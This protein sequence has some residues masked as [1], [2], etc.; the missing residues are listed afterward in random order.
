MNF[1]LTNE[2]ESLKNII[3]EFAETKIE[4][5]SFQ[6]DEKSI[7]PEKI[8]KEMGEL[9]IMGIPYPKKYGGAGMDIL[10]YAIAVE[11]LSRVDAGVGVALSA[12][13][14]LGSWPIME[15][16]TEE[17]KEK[18]LTPLAS[19]EKIGAFGLTEEN[20]GSDASNTET[21]AVLKGDHYI[22]NGAKIFITNGGYAQI[23]VIFAVT[24]PGIG[25][26][27][28]SAFI[29]ENDWEG[30]T[31]GTHY[32][33]MGIRSSATAELLFRD[34]KVPAENLLGKEG[35]GFKIA[36]MTLEG[37][38]IGIAAQ[39]LG[40]AQGA[41]EKALEYSKERVQFGKP[42][43][44]QQVIA[45]KLAD[46]AT[47]IR[48]ARFMVYSAAELKQEHES[49]GTE[50]AMAKL[51]ASDVCLEVVNDAVQIYG[52][53]GYIKGFAVE[54]MYRDA[55]ICT[56]YE[57]TNEIHKL[58]ISHSILH[59]SKKTPTAS[60]ISATNVAEIKP[61]A[62]VVTENRKGIIIKEGSTE[63]KIATLINYLKIEN[64]KS[65]D[66][67]NVHL[68][69]NIGDADK[70][71]SIGRGLVDQKDLPI[72]EALAE[73]MGAQVGCSRPVAEENEWMP[74]DRYVGISGQ[75]FKGSLY[76]AIGI[77]GQVQHVRGIR[78]AKIIVAINTDER[79]PIFSHADY[80]IVG[81][82]YEV[83]PMLT[84]V[85]KKG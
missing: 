43:C 44:E 40:I 47:K 6:L 2:Q 7:F 4:P 69:G 74:L 8:I 84:E 29:V 82:L 39:A 13:V 71:C 53:Y 21:T 18:Y 46:M 77:S 33:K 49:Y 11:E 54:R 22:L 79:A 17:Q 15:F 57:G 24:T 68:G 19:G 50:S 26:R 83:V 48:A 67:S 70:V 23:Y 34:V 32:N 59:N 38:R 75:K 66:S 60:V 73:A 20:A 76:L 85:L 61:A 78:D 80:G 72:I 52:G 10:T 12:H 62:K 55:K 81:D 9:D 25:T 36:M 16:G 58:I 27:G 64:I 28:I 45:F 5:I 56:I 31:F 3:R 37:G 30:F 35:Q 41:Y 65:Q 51:Y 42:I 63:E 14:S 1:K